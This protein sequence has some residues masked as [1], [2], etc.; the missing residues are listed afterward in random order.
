M[1]AVA[2]QVQIKT[3]SRLWWQNWGLLLLFMLPPLAAEPIRV[4]LEVS[5]PHQTFD[6]GQVAG[7]STEVVELMLQQAGLQPRYEVYPWARAFRLAASTPNVLIYNMARTPERE[8]QFDWIG[9]VA[10]YQFGLLKLTSRYDIKVQQLSDIHGYVVGA[11]REDFAVE[12]LKNVAKQ[13]ANR[14]QLQ[15]DVVETWRLF[16]KGKLDLMI[17]DPNAIQAMLD[18]HQLTRADVQFVLFV[19]ELELYSWIAIKKGSDP[20]L[21]LRLRQAY[22]QI[23][24]SPQ[25]QK[26]LRPELTGTLTDP[27]FAQAH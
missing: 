3:G 4:V 6:N 13:P 12:W 19:P 17:D 25:L 8:G 21:V 18:K 1:V 23:E 20:A 15:P 7:L 24:G 11:Q 26:V 2:V 27:A 14:L 22:A 5:P 10:R 9:K 16:A